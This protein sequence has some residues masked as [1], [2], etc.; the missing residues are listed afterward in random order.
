MVKRRLQDLRLLVELALAPQALTTHDV[1]NVG[2]EY[3]GRAGV[4][5][6]VGDLDPAVA[7]KLLDEGGI[8]LAEQLDT[9]VAPGIGAPMLVEHEM[10]ALREKLG[11]TRKGRTGPKLRRDIGQNGA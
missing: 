1:G 11:D 4:R 6:L 7:R 10:A 2:L 3:D 5:L 8:G 9:R